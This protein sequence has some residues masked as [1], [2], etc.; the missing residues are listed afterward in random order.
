[1]SA[2][3]GVRVK[4][5]PFD[6]WTGAISSSVSYDP[7][8]HG[9]FDLVGVKSA[10]QSTRSHCSHW[11]EIATLMACCSAFRDQPHNVCKLQKLEMHEDTNMQ[12]APE[13]PSPHESPERRLHSVYC[14]GPIK[15]RSM[16]W[17]S[18]LER[19]TQCHID[20][21]DDI[22]GENDYT[23]DVDV[24]QM[25]RRLKRLMRDLEPILEVHERNPVLFWDDPDT[26]QVR[27]ST[28]LVP[29]P[30]LPIM[31]TMATPKQVHSLVNMLTNEIAAL[32]YNKWAAADAKAS[33]IIL[34]AALN[35]LKSTV[36]TEKAAS[37]RDPGADNETQR[38]RWENTASF[39][40]SS[41]SLRSNASTVSTVSCRYSTSDAVAHR[42]RVTISDRISIVIRREGIEQAWEQD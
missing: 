19:C 4:E 22:A 41:E 25:N 15:D 23:N 26:V 6:K 10:P 2:F 14:E 27:C 24:V 8:N 36:G 5:V 35:R 7:N 32:E 42:K 9:S 38:R 11:P 40:A 3:T 34:K 31:L 16:E 17:T 37:L 1:M 12:C 21:E 30:H 33:K 13:L 28:I 39:A 20:P 29:T 18:T